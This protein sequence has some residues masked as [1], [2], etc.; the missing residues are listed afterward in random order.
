V[1]DFVGNVHGCYRNQPA[2]LGFCPNKIEMRA[3]FEPL[4]SALGMPATNPSA[5]ETEVGGA[6]VKGHPSIHSEFKACLSYVGTCLK[7]KRVVERGGEERRKERGEK[8]EKLKSIL[9]KILSF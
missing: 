5:Q 7:Q 1:P 9:L 2:S 4:K 6:K 3:G 8:T